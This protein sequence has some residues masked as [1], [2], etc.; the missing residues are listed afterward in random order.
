MKPAA[1]DAIRPLRAH[2]D[3]V[4]A[5]LV[6]LLNERARWALAIGEVKAAAGWPLYE[7][8]REAEILERV[9][10][11]GGGPLSGAALRRL[12]ER[13]ID[14]SRSLERTAGG[15]VSDSGDGQLD[16]E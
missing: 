12:F 4:D 1:G 11:L 16:G 15:K 6:E 7:P 13:I 9:V 2:I 5:R 10:R 3:A 8:A 14:E